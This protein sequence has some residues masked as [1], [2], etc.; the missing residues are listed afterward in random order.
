[1]I[2]K[3]FSNLYDSVIST[4]AARLRRLDPGLVEE[5]GRESLRDNGWDVAQA[6]VPLVLCMDG[7]KGE[8]GCEFSGHQGSSTAF[9]MTRVLKSV[10]TELEKCRV[11]ASCHLGKGTKVKE[12]TQVKF[13]VCLANLG[14]HVQEMKWS[15]HL[16]KANFIRT[17]QPESSKAP[18]LGS[19][20]D[21]YTPTHIISTLYLSV[22]E[23]HT[24]TAA[25]TFSQADIRT[26]TVVLP[27]KTDAVTEN[28]QVKQA[29]ARK[30]GFRLSG[31]CSVLEKAAGK[32][33][34][35]VNGRVPFDFRGPINMQ[36]ACPWRPV[37]CVPPQEHANI[38]TTPVSEPRDV[39]SDTRRAYYEGD[40]E[41]QH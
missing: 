26:G 2:L 19:W 25:L 6:G 13:T 28:P 33:C 9:M 16:I 1:M 34:F 4:A 21:E 10:M 38:C 40:R 3:V 11:K 41:I 23:Q 39:S 36:T 8:G 27:E 17:N 32:Q 7:G 20:N 37:H 29:G 14:A 24:V 5:R 15:Q 30:K 22:E 31:K 35:G 12:G 18:I